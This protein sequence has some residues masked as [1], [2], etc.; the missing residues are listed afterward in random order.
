[1]GSGERLLHVVQAE[2]ERRQL[3]ERIE[4]SGGG[5]EAERRLQISGATVADVTV[6]GCPSCPASRPKLDTCPS[7]G[8]KPT[9]D[10]LLAGGLYHV[11][12]QPTAAAG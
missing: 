8:G 4:V 7:P 6:P 12:L 11:M 2:R 10:V 5:E 1:M 9:Q 3:L